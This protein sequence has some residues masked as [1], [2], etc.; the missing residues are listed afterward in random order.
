MIQMPHPNRMTA[1][2]PIRHNLLDCEADDGSGPPDAGGVSPGDRLILFDSP[3][4]KM[5]G[6]MR[7]IPII[8]SSSAYTGHA[9][10]LW[11][12]IATM[13]TSQ[14][15]AAAPMRCAMARL[16]HHCGK[17][18]CDVDQPSNCAPSRITMTRLNRPVNRWV[19]DLPPS[20]SLARG[21][22]LCCALSLVRRGSGRGV[23]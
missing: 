4:G 6:R 23:A 13:V 10:S 11:V 14:V 17:G 21:E 15:R 2:S 9:S 22:P 3:C 20:P 7:P 18:A 5:R 8:S 12:A 16:A 1:A 19:G